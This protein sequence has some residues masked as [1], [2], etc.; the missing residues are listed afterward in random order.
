MSGP[1]MRPSKLLRKSV[2]PLATAALLGGAL[3]PSAAD[4]AGHRG[5]GAHS[6]PT[7]VDAGRYLRLQVPASGHGPGYRVVIQRSPFRITT[8]RGGRTVLQTTEGG[9][10]SSGPA[11]F[12]TSNGPATATAV[13]GASWHDGAV[14]LTLATS[15]PGDAVSYRIKPLADRYKVS[16]SVQGSVPADRVATSYDTAS[17]GHWYGQG[18]A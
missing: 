18:E 16:W 4:A 9:A 5:R 7:F 11:G 6:A 2:V 12:H 13:K 15:I 17:A 3:A 14:H 8:E 10:G 1:S